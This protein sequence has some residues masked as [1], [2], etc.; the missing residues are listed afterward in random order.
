MRKGALA[1]FV[2]TV[3]ACAR[4]VSV[5]QVP[6]HGGIA[7]DVRCPGNSEACLVKAA[8]LCSSGHDVLGS[9]GHEQLLVQCRGDDRLRPATPSLDLADAAAQQQRT[10][11]Q[12]ASGAL[13]SIY[14]VKT[15]VGQGMGFCIRGG[16]IVTTLHVVTG[17]FVVF[18]LDSSGQRHRVTGVRAFDAARDL[19]V[20]D[21][22]GLSPCL[23]L[24]PSEMPAAGAPVVVVGNPHGS[25]GSHASGVIGGT[26]SASPELVLLQVDASIS[27][28]S[29]GN[30]VLNPEGKVVAVLINTLSTGHNL[31]FAIPVSTIR[32]MR[33]SV[34]ASKGLITMSTFAAITAQPAAQPS[35]VSAA[36]ARR[37]RPAFPASVAGFALG[38]SFPEAQ[39]LC[40]DQLI[41]DSNFATCSF[42]PVDV[43]FAN[44]NVSLRFEAGVLTRVYL[45]GNSWDDVTSVTLAKYGQPNLVEIRNGG[46]WIQ[47]SG[48]K[49][50]TASRATWWLDGGTL[51][52][53]SLDGRDL[54]LLYVSAA[55][56]PSRR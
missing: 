1:F 45:R 12:I 3:V 54:A 31:N 8:E 7:Y 30:P 44:N 41:G 32:H 48:W 24:A 28:G 39:K 6:G 27:P 16:A 18:T 35:A 11:E 34:K 22:A 5:R 14:L 51:V 26:R 50:G 17:Q 9:E 55:V 42:E 40:N 36:S 15:P 13:R 46:S 29:S 20:L 52:V 49:K 33:D 53:F 4:G 25:P 43:P 19:A 56:E 47:G 38:I 21:A 37:K 10:P 2:L 23:E